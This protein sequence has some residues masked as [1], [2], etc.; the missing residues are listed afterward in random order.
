MFSIRSRHEIPP[1]HTLIAH[2][3]PERG[4]DDD[5]SAGGESPFSD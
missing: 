1:L 2:E 4:W 5:D 3:S